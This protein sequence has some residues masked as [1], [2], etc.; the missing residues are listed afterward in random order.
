[1][2]DGVGGNSE[3]CLKWGGG[4]GGHQEISTKITL[5]GV[6]CSLRRGS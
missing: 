3:V 1:M 5:K 4:G 2:V 6:N